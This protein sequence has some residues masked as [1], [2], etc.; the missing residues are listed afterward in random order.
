MHDI[1]YILRN[2]IQS[3]EIIY[4]LRSVDQNF[5]HNS[6][7]IY[8]GK[9]DSIK[10]DHYVKYKQL[11]GSKYMKVTNTLREICNNDDITEQFY[12]FNDDFFIMQQVEEFPTLYAGTLWERCDRIR[13]RHGRD[14]GYSKNLRETAA[15]LEREGYGQLDYALHCPIL[16][17]RRKALDTL[18]QF[19]GYP[20]FR[21]LYG[22]H[23][24]IGGQW[25]KDHKIQN[26]TD[27]PGECLFVST[28]DKSFR[29]GAVGKT[30]RTMFKEPSRFEA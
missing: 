3:D 27:T 4:S 10:P 8:G 7:W 18:D 11:G 23:H 22:N 5:R 9:P 21:S 12:L 24:S 2:D 20:M 29:F 30:L 25:A 15:L 28:S 13:E 19:T 17:D 26:T 14:S 1:V 6:V 16:I